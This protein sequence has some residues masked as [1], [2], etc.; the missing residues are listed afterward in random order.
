MICLPAYKHVDKGHKYNI[1]SQGFNW[2]EDGMLETYT[3]LLLII[4]TVS[5]SYCCKHICQPIGLKILDILLFLN[6]GKA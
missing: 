2:S 5:M 3:L 1:I 6:F 4:E